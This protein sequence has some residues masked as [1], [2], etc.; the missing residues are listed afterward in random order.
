MIT[1]ITP[2]KMGNFLLCYRVVL[3]PL[4]RQRSYG[5]IPQSHAILYYSQRTTKGGLLIGE[6]TVI[7]ESGIGYKD[8][9]GIWTKEQV[10]AWKPIVNAIHAKGGIFFFSQIW[11]AGRGSNKDFQPNEQDPVSCT[12]KLLIPQIRPDGLDDEHFTSP[13]RLTTNEIP[14]FVNEFRLAAKNAIEAGFDGVEIHKANGYLIDQFVKDQ[15]NDR[16]DKYGGS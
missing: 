1:L 16:N 9:H 8:V 12:D 14:Q 15:I 7:S 11:H 10:E 2:Y 4:I 5:N 3:A 13:R 6:A